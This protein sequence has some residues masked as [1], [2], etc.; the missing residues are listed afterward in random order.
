MG[1]R[2]GEVIKGES[3]VWNVVGL[4]TLLAQ[5]MPRSLCA[6]STSGAQIISEGVVCVCTFLPVLPWLRDLFLHRF[7]T[8]V[9]PYPVSRAR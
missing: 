1:V 7:S 2:M 9:Q 8:V 5:A 6:F 3:R 4:A